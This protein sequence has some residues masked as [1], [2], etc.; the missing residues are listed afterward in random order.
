METVMHARFAGVAIAI[1]TLGTAVSAE[2]PKAPAKE[3]AQRT[4]RAAPAVLLA[5]AEQVTAP[6]QSD[7]ATQQ[8][9]PH[10]AARV[11][12]CRCGGQTEEQPDQ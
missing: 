2:P 11:T 6:A 9:K 8:P 1:L 5:S 10:R 12:T 4:N 7:Q 3:A